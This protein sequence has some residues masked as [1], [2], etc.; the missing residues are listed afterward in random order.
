MTG[1]R[2]AVLDVV[3][4]GLSA[5]DPAGAVERRV[6]LRKRTLAVDGRKYELD[7]RGILLVGAGKASLRLAQVVEE[8][9]GPCIDGGVIVVPTGTAQSLNRVECIEADHPLPGDRSV[10]AA[11]A[12]LSVTRI[13]DGRPII[14]C[15]TGGSSALACAPPG[16]VTLADKR[17]LHHLLIRSGASITEIN[18]V[19]KHVSRIKGGRLAA[20]AAPS[21]IV[22]LTISDVA[23]DPLDAITDPS[24][25]DTTST[26]DAIDILVRHGLWECVS[27]NIRAHLSQ[28]NSESP[29]LNGRLLQASLLIT[30]KTVCDAMACRA[31][32]LGFMPEIILNAE[33]EG[34]VLG[35]SL[36][37]RVSDAGHH[38]PDADHDELPRVIVGCGGEATVSLGGDAVI[39]AGGPNLEAALAAGLTI[40][41]GNH[42]S[43]VFLDTDGRDGSSPFAGAIVDGLTSRRAGENGLDVDKALAAHTA[44]EPL[45]QLGDAIITGDTGTN[46]NDLFVIAAEAA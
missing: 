20:E 16:E 28:S 24:V 23:W 36:V 34:S 32:E 5:C 39:G 30:G 37:K 8:R 13:A 46:V 12:A 26:N 43:A 9:I 33:G 3:E 21:S 35:P 18:T 25:Q 7:G 19:R 42:V 29:R 11:E 10:A 6:S 44:S 40:E 38:E 17:E 45:A 1:L 15:F 41:D 27:S 14:T 22:A 2:Q 31:T 4:S